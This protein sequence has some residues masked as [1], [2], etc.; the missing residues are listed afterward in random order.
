MDKLRGQHPIIELIERYRE[1]T[2]LIST[3]IEALPKLMA[4]DGRIH[5]TFNQDV[6]ST[7]RLSS[8]NPNL[9]NIPV[10]TELGRK[11]RQAFVPS[12]GKVFVGADY[13]QFEL[14]LA[15]VLAGDEKLI[16]DFNSD[17]DIHAKTAAETYGISIDEVSKSQRRAAKV[18]NFGVLYG[19]SPHGLAAA[20]GMS[21]T[22][23]KKFIDHYFEVRKPISSVL[24][25]NFNSS[26]RT[27][28]C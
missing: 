22:E 21:F 11:I 28:I 25:Q 10:R 23:A 20:T 9:Q 5:T 14:R 4:T 16:E 19:M 13:S 27:G 7:G 26:T 15:A 2:K 24:G 6:T 3:Y 17:V 8:T 18:I 1:L 12:D